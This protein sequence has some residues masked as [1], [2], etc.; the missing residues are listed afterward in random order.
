MRFLSSLE[1]G[2]KKLH[3]SIKATLSIGALAFPGLSCQSLTSP[4]ITDGV[5][6]DLQ[7][8][9][10]LEE[11]ATAQGWTM[12]HQ[13]LTLSCV[14]GGGPGKSFGPITSLSGLEK[15]PLLTML[16]VSDNQ[17][18]DA[19]FSVTSNPTLLAL[20]ISDNLV[21]TINN[22]NL[23]APLL[24]ILVAN[25]NALTALDLSGVNNLQALYVPNNAL[26]SLTVPASVKGFPGMPTMNL[27]KIPGVVAS[28]N[29]LSSVDLSAATNLT[30]LILNDN[31]LTAAALTGLD[32]LDKL[33]YLEL[34]NNSGLGAV[35]AIDAVNH[36]NLKAL[37]LAN[38]GLS[39]VYTVP[40][41]PSLSD[42]DLDALG[43]LIKVPGLNVADNSLTGIAFAPEHA[44]LKSLV[45][46]SNS[47]LLGGV[48]GLSNLT[49]I[50]FI[51]LSNNILM[52]GLG[53][54]SANSTLQGLGLAATGILAI[55]YLSNLPNISSYNLG[56]QELP[57]L[58]L[59]G[60]LFS[61]LDLNFR[62]S[63]D[64]MPN[65]KSLDMSS[66]IF[67]TLLSILWLD[68]GA[69]CLSYVVPC[70]ITH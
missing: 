9:A 52:L 3:P 43:T 64:A 25:N 40:I 37:G 69:D 68:S 6:A 16:D 63:I 8:Q 18:T 7:L 53:I 44:N 59:A 47:I 30:A 66:N 42:Y 10:C 36:P 61:I 50:E 23:T 49:S 39:G 27:P 28:N 48:T 12:V 15:L 24:Q 13:V 22:A 41:I 20:L 62:N 60:N 11:V 35:S 1:R 45:G 17:I 58:N 2:L 70:T 14:D 21:S 57:G 54:T 46:T 26:T 38:T 33:E 51:E 29:S 55:P 5:F 31:N 34:S 32:Q 19:G 56:G 65:L 4:L 67:L